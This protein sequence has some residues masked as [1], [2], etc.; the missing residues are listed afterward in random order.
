MSL[1]RILS[2][3]TGEFS[4]RRTL[5]RL[6]ARAV[7]YEY[8]ADGRQP[9]PPSSDVTDTRATSPWPMWFFARR[10]FRGLV[11][12]NLRTALWQFGR[13]RTLFAKPCGFR[14]IAARSVPKPVRNYSSVS[15]IARCIAL[16]L[17]KTP[18]I[19]GGSEI[20]PAS[21]RQTYPRRSLVGEPAGR[22]QINPTSDWQLRKRPAACR[23]VAQFATDPQRILRP[24]PERRA[25][26][27]PP[28]V[29]GAAVLA[30]TLQLN[31]DSD[32]ETRRL[33]RR[34]MPEQCFDTTLLEIR[35]SR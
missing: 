24:L 20:S 26:L 8:K 7:E 11:D 21:S 35:K 3:L 32:A 22:R 28:A 27:P 12:V 23:D 30:R 18:K 25:N 13:R 16:L 10:R 4:R 29:E 6:D 19:W 5:R 9:Y 14:P 2:A 33:P 1:L 15:L 34:A 31:S 17:R